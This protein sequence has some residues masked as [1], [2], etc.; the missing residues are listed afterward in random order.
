MIKR[1]ILFLLASLWLHAEEVQVQFSPS[2]AHIQ[3]TLDSVLHTVKGTFRFKSGSIRFEPAGGQASGMLIADAASGESGDH[4]RDNRM[5]KEIIQST[6]YPEITFAPDS[7]D[8]RVNMN[9]DSTIQV[10]GTFGIHGGLHEMTIPAQVHIENGAVNLT[11]SFKIP[12]IAWGM[13][14]PSTLFLRVGNTVRIDMQA[15]GKLES[16]Q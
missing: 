10:H 5:H 14:N 7:I 4:A 13:K 12:Y 15:A 8:G 9:G 6:K 1:T 3:Y 2:D 11:T 16:A